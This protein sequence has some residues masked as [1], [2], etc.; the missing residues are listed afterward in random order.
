MG[1]ASYGWMLQDA[2][3]QPFTINSCY[4]TNPALVGTLSP[5]CVDATTGLRAPL[6]RMPTI[7]KTSLG[8]ECVRSWST[9]LW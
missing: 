9:Q 4:T 7:S 8:G 5:R 2:T 6:V 1:T 3:F